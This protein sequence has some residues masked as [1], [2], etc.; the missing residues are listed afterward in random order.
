MGKA[1]VAA[2]VLLAGVQRPEP[3]DAAAVLPALLFGSEMPGADRTAGLPQDAKDA[4]TVYQR[5]S[6]AFRPTTPPAPR[7]DNWESSVRYKR[8]GVERALFSLFDR[9]DSAALAADYAR[10]AN[11]A[12]EWEGFPEVP[13]GEARFPE[14]FLA[15]QPNSPIAGY[16][17]LF[18][19]HRNMCAANLMSE[20]GGKDPRHP[21]VRA[22]AERHLKA[23]RE[24]GHPLIREV[25]DYL[26]RTGRCFPQ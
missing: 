14:A 10:R 26:L 6:R 7:P 20:L 16:A 15:E 13:L 9:P 11:L 25:A 18:A 8:V 2:L 24:S 3:A 4:L 1:A 19:G 17:R 22:A 5:R 23:A 21:A 12:Y